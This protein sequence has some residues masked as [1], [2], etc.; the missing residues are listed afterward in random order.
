M[1]FAN[2]SAPSDVGQARMPSLSELVSECRP[3]YSLSLVICGCAFVLLLHKSLRW[4]LA[5]PRIGLQSVSNYHREKAV[6]DGS[7]F[8]CSSVVQGLCLMPARRTFIAGSMQVCDEE[9]MYMVALHLVFSKNLVEVLVFKENHKN[10]NIT[11]VLCIVSVA[12]Q[13]DG[14]LTDALDIRMRRSRIFL[15]WG[16]TL[17]ADVAWLLFGPLYHLNVNRPPLQ[18]LAASLRFTTFVLTTSIST[19]TVLSELVWSPEMAPSEGVFF[20]SISF[21]CITIMCNRG[22][23][24]FIILRKKLRERMRGGTP[25]D[26]QSDSL[27]RLS[28]RRRKFQKAKQTSFPLLTAVSSTV[29]LVRRLPR[30]APAHASAS[31]ADAGSAP[32]AAEPEGARTVQLTTHEPALASFEEGGGPAAGTEANPP[33][34]PPMEAAAPDVASITIDSASEALSGLAQP[35]ITAASSASEA[36]RLTLT[37]LCVAIG[38]AWFSEITYLYVLAFTTRS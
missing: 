34:A 17:G 16:L 33:S 28:A 3:P 5:H 2:T 9:D 12:L 10:V 15:I 18:L 19:A 37:A 14:V 30:C 1:N 11:R 31:S 38:V 35:R 7:S 20:W 25:A 26:V 23:I 32:T 24:Y 6:R 13:W 8:I 22:L 36:W 27:D 29:A 21:L 4:L